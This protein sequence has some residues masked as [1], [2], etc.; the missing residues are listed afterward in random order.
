MATILDGYYALMAFTCLAANVWVFFVFCAVGV[1]LRR[2]ER[3]TLLWKWSFCLMILALIC[4]FMFIVF[5]LFVKSHY[6][7][8]EALWFLYIGMY[9]V[10]LISIPYSW[11]TIIPDD[12]DYLNWKIRTIMMIIFTVCDVFYLSFFT[13]TYQ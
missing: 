3:L 10:M 1:H 11:G 6:C 12:K 5:A 7:Y 2:N 9:S 13:T 4:S 8:F